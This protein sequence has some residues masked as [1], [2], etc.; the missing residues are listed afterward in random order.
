MSHH[1]M[2][3]WYELAS[4]DTAAA[5]QFY[6]AVLGWSWTNSNTPGM[7][8]LMA[9]TATGMVA[10]MMKVESP[11]QPVAWSFYTAVD[12]CD[13]TAAKAQSLGAKLIVPPADIPGTGRF[14]VLID[15]QGAGFAILQPL[16]GGQA[17]A[18]DQKQTGHGNWHDHAS[19]DAKAA[20]AFYGALFGW[21]VSRSMPM[22]P[23]MTYHVFAANGQ[24]IGGFFDQPGPA[25]WCVYFGT[26][27]AAATIAAITKAGGH[28][29]HGPAEVPGGAF[30]VQA[31]D[32]QGARF[33]VV[34]PA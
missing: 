5:Q 23:T 17:G 6:T 3:C 2:P 4:S 34:G 16:P 18:F 33:A 20:A 27:S 19:P 14:A 1:G 26:S 11:E 12:D 28:V 31:H 21:T 13:A 24:D 29:L 30:I 25:A 22:G 10:G 8:Y 7:E 9:S 15:P 32:P